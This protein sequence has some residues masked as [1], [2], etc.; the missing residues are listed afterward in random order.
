MG[1]DTFLQLL[2]TG[3][4]E[5]KRLYFPSPTAKFNGEASITRDCLTKEKPMQI[6]LLP[7]LCNMGAFRNEDPKKQGTPCIQ[8]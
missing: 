3:S 4:V 7:V 6:Y 8:A 2:P 5:E 1:R